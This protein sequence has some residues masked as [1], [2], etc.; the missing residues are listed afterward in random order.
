LY[1]PHLGQLGARDAHFGVH[2]Q[3]PGGVGVEEEEEEEEIS[4]F[5][6]GV[7]ALLRDPNVKHLTSRAVCQSE[8][9]RASTGGARVIG[10]S[11]TPGGC[12]IGYMGGV[13]LVTYM[14]TIPAVID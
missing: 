12:Q 5:F 1:S 4:L 13:R 9:Q 6:D 3:L 7:P 14:D 10:L 11:L 2:D 8:Q